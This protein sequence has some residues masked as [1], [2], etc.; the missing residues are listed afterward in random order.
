MKTKKQIKRN[1]KPISLDLHL[2]YRCSNVDCGYYHWLSLKE[3]QTK[4]F[5]VVCDCG[6]VFIPKRIQQV[7][8]KY[9]KKK[10][11]PKIKEQKE[12]KTV[13]KN[14]IEPSVLEKCVRALIQ[15]GFT[16]LES[17]DLVNRSFEIVQKN[18]VS[19]IIKKSLE[20]I[21]ENKI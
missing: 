5:K 2:R 21:G 1:Q 3:T 20:L 10:I 13:I 14:S 8:V 15:Y 4:N 12:T 16:K 7:K 19:L 11:K 17:E 18:D 6:T 9:H